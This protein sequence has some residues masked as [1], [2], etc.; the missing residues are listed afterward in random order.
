MYSEDSNPL[1]DVLPI[2]KFYTDML[3]K[4]D[5]ELASI[6]QKKAIEAATAVLLSAKMDLQHQLDKAFQRSAQQAQGE[7]FVTNPV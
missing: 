4:V 5:Q 7:S 2:I 6:E 1:K 3:R